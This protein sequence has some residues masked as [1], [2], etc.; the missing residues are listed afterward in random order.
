MARQKVCAVES[1]PAFAAPASAFCPG[2]RSAKR[3]QAVHKG[4]GCS[5]CHRMLHAGDYVTIDS[6]PERLTHAHCPEPTPRG[7]RTV[8]GSTPLFDERNGSTE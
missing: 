5:K 1:C 2:H 8:K 7:P 6:T 4:R 3:L